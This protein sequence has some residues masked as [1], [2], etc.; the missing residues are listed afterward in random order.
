M[1]KPLPK[2]SEKKTRKER[3]DKEVN[4]NCIRKIKKNLFLPTTIPATQLLNL[5]LISCQSCSYTVYKN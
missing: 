5:I 1:G 3:T 2:E 4:E